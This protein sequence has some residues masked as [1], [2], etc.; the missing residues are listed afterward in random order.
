MPS[1]TV[2][3]AGVGAE[4]C[5]VIPVLNEE[6]NIA[7]LIDCVSK[8]LAGVAWEIVFVDDDS[9]DGTRAAIAAVAA[10]D[11]RVRMIHRIG[12]RGLSSAFIEGAHSSFA[13]FVAAMDGDLQH[14]ETVLPKMLAALRADECDIAIGSRYV[15]GGGVGEWDATR[16]GMSSLATRLAGIVLRTRVSD[17]MSGFFML[18]REVFDQAARKLSAMGFKILL[19]IIA[20]LPAAPRI[21]ELP[22][23]FRTRVSGESKLDAGVLRDYILL[24]VDKLV[25]HIVPVRFILFAGVGAIGI[26][27]HLLVLRTGLR[28]G[29]LSFAAAQTLATAVAIVGNFSL[30]NTFTFREGRLKGSRFLLGLL[31]FSLISSVGAYMNVN[32]SALLVGET[33]TAWYVA[34][35]L[36]AVMSLVWNYAVS[37]AVTWRRYTHAH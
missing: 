15:E 34:G 37:S 19:D 24:I 3:R 13:P 14:D 4:L 18:K 2:T 16:A 36:G 27:A 9:G 29:G 28:F 7:P 11:P 25:G 1:S 30:N 35:V 8:A 26:A 12:R 23:Q 20:S 22:Y 31:T 33:H 5:L 6:G 32:I 17:P 10:H 21:K